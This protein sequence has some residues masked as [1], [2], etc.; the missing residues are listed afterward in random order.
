M[1]QTTGGV[2]TKNVVICLDGT[3]NEPERGQTNVARI[4]DIALKDPDRQVAYYDPGVGTMGARSATTRLGKF[5]TR[6]S[7]LAFG[8][9]IQ[10]NI[11]EAYEFLMKAWEPGDRIFLFGF[12]RGAY[13]ARALA[14]LLRSVG[15]LEAGATNLV[16]YALKMYAGAPLSGSS[17]KNRTFWDNVQ[18]WSTT[19]GRQEFNRF[20]KPIHYLGVWDTVKFVGWFNITG[21][22]RQAK[23]P[24]TRNVDAVAHGRH[25]VSIDEKRRYYAEYRFDDEHVA[26]ADRDLREVW[27]AGVHS[28][29][30]GGFEEHELADLSL[31]WI[32]DDAIDHELLIRPGKYRKHLS[33]APREPLPAT[34]ATADAHP[35]SLGWYFAGAGWRRRKVPPGAEVHSSVKSRIAEPGLGYSPTLDSATYVDE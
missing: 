24:F 33:T 9:G 17:A 29:V 6:V 21:R 13:T 20:E 35:N 32:V 27:F 1:H 14:G 34:H 12:S 30:G 28:D 18:R 10:E 22:F 25:A 4:F 23:W 31:K 7:G 8:H 3:A 5:A 16:P 26:H 2:V 15:L 11:A 19:F